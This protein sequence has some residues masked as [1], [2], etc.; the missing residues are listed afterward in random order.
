MTFGSPPV[1]L[2]L[3]EAKRLR[4]IAVSS[5]QRFALLPG[6]PTMKESGLADFQTQSWYGVFVPAGTPSDIVAL[7]ATHIDR[8]VK[9]PE[10]RKVFGAGG[11]DPGGG[12]SEE[13]TA[14]FMGD[15]K[16]WATVAKKAGVRID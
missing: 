12:T 8:A 7:L 10:V 9:T 15:L 16:R 5:S 6:V 4:V 1:L 14:L 3:V 2:P 11:L 13:F